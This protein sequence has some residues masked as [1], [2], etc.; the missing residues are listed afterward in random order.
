M[1]S[2]A[3]IIFVL[4]GTLMLKSRT[5][6]LTL[7]MVAFAHVGRLSAQQPCSMA[8]ATPT[9]ELMRLMQA[10][11][12]PFVF[13]P[14]DAFQVSVYGVKEYTVAA[15]LSTDGTVILPLAGPVKLIGLT[16]EEAQNKIADQLESS[17]M[18]VS[19]QI[20]L[21]VG[22][23]PSMVVPVSGELTKPG[24]FPNVGNHRLAE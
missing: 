5:A 3:G 18:I 7:T 24:T 2:R 23:S 10:P 22:E 16:V 21:V 20:S 9:E 17:G 12:P 13:K 4:R 19:P 15:R 6:I 1:L 11:Q 14:G 8:L